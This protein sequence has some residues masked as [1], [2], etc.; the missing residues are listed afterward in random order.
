VPPQPG[1]AYDP[2]GAGSTFNATG[3]AVALTGPA[4]V[5]FNAPFEYTYDNLGEFVAFHTQTPLS[6]ATGSYSEAGYLGAPSLTLPAGAIARYEGLGLAA[7]Q[8]ATG[9]TPAFIGQAAFAAVNFRNGSAMGGFCQPSA[10]GGGS[11]QTPAYG[12]QN[13]FFLGKVNGLGLTDTHLFGTGNAGGPILFQ[14]ALDGASFYGSAHQGLGIAGTGSLFDLGTGLQTGTFDLTAATM[15][16]EETVL[17]PTY[18]STWNGFAVGAATPVTGAPGL[19]GNTAPSGVTLNLDRAAGAV[20]GALNLSSGANTLSAT[21]GD[22]ASAY[23]DD[24][25]LIATLTDAGV[26]PGRSSVDTTKPGSSFLV[27]DPAAGNRSEWYSWGYWSFTHEDAALAANSFHIPLLSGLWVAGEP[28]EPR[29]VKGLMNTPNAV[30]VYSGDARCLEARGTQVNTLL[31]TSNLNVFFSTHDVQGRFAFPTVS[32]QAKG[33]LQPDG[34]GFSGAVTAVD[35]PAAPA[36]LTSGSTFQGGFLGPQANA[37]AGSLGA[38]L[39]DG[40]TYK[41]V[42]AGNR[43]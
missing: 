18:A 14:G 9:A 11:A 17:I 40:S 31:G 6:L 21:V 3:H 7:L 30:G 13:L 37:V 1:G 16:Q 23:V 12:T 5:T 29:Y 38:T 41:A 27:T 35:R 19:Y 8:P 28:T 26:G 36:A 25:R 43:Q 20:T 42:F 24:H 33:T 39:S 22:S 4:T 10:T 32:M 2:A 34:S 15:K